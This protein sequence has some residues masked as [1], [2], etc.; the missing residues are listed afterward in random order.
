[1]KVLTGLCSFQRLWGKVRGSW[2]RLTA[3]GVCPLSSVLQSDP[4]L[5]SLLSGH[6]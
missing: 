6:R 3:A 4:L 2:G 1:M 5:A